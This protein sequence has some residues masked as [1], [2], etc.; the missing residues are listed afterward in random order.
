MRIDIVTIF[1][2]V[3]DSYLQVGIVGRAIEKGIVEV[4]I[5]NLRDFSDNPHKKVDDYPYGGGA[6]MVFMPEPL[7]KAVE[8]IKQS[9]GKVILTSPQGN[10]FNQNKALELTAEKQVLIICGRYRGFDQ[11]FIDG[12]VDEEISIGNFIL[13]G[14]ELP[15]LVI[16]EALIRLIPKAINNEEN[17]KLD[18]FSDGFLEEELYTRPRIVRN[19]EVPEV[20]I[21]GDHQKIRKWRLKR[22]EQRTKNKKIGFLREVDYAS[23][24]RDRSFTA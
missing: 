22:R 19:I 17:L 23:D 6:G 20:L 8:S 4:N 5:H 9:D 21:S 16:S 1:P 7:I 18:S 15:A 11:R 24:K 2:E 3:I 14:G 10:I 13:S 12:W